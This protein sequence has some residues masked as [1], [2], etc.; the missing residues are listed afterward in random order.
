MYLHYWH[1]FRYLVESG[2]YLARHTD[3][4][5]SKV[6]IAKSW[7]IN[8]SWFVQ[9]YCWIWCLWGPEVLPLVDSRLEALLVEQ[10]HQSLCCCFLGTSLLL[11]HTA[12]HS[13]ETWL[14]DWGNLLALN[15][16]RRKKEKK[17]VFSLPSQAVPFSENWAWQKPV[18]VPSLFFPLAPI[19]HTQCIYSFIR[20]ESSIWIIS[21]S[22]R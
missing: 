15:I 21:N 6:T 13:G 10:G 7:Q 19:T 3:G 22:Q 20:S 2:A 5:T 8:T 1:T 18:P 14:A 12:E 9:I 11:S 16:C 4:Y 17:S